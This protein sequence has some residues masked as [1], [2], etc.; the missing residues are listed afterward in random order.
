MAEQAQSDRATV[1]KISVFS[2]KTW[3]E[4]AIYHL[5]QLL[6]KLFCMFILLQ[7]KVCNVAAISLPDV[8]KTLKVESR[9]FFCFQLLSKSDALALCVF[10]LSPVHTIVPKQHSQVKL[11]KNGFNKHCSNSLQNTRDGLQAL[12]YTVSK[13]ASQVH[14]RTLFIS[15]YRNY[16]WFHSTHSSQN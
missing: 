6:S 14:E 11:L 16:F 9:M 13:C 10:A 5:E 3:R 12:L 7:K 15:L 4:P 1:T 2:I 8:A